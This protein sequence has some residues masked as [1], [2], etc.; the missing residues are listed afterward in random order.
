M[1]TSLPR[2]FLPANTW[3]DLYAATG[4]VA[5]TQLIIQNTGS[6][7]VI[8][9]ESATAPETNSTGFNLLPARDFFT[10]AAANVGGWAFSKQ[11]SSLQVEEV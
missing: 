9:V 6:D 5:G 1:S 10:N 7:E 8:L 2:V 4:I 11:G 3:V